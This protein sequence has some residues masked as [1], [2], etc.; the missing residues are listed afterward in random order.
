MSMNEGGIIFEHFDTIVDPR[1]ERTKYHELL[2]I[3]A[4]TICAVI[5]GANTW[6]EVEI[7]GETKNEWLSTFLALPN[8]IPSHDTFGR[9]FAM[10]DG[11]EFERSF[12]SWVTT[13]AELSD[14]DIVA[15]DGKT[16]RRSHDRKIGKDAIHLVSAF[17]CRNGI[18]LG[19]RAIDTKSNE[20]KAI[21]KLLKILSISG[22]TVTI[23]AAGCY[24]EVVDMIVEQE[25]NYVIAVKQ[26]QPTLYDDI[27]KIFEEHKNDDLP[28][29]YTEEK[30]H[31]RK[32]LR[33]CW[34][35]NTEQQLNQIHKKERWKHLNSVVKITNTRTMND[36]SCI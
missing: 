11:E 22:C 12:V 14:G 16:N 8:G 15:I 13:I 36:P 33:E 1:V 5:C 18:T 21:P 4:I 10:I 26:N 19:Q 25:A 2:D 7:F 17:A 30:N 20:M 24:T 32:E 34:V 3:I 9:V 35:I 27:E 29:A 31:G 28:Y 23:D 6:E